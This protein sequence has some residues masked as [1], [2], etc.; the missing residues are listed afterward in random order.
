[1]PS[2]TAPPRPALSMLLAAVTAAVACTGD[3][4]GPEDPVPTPGGRHA[5]S[6]ISVRAPVGSEV[7]VGLAVTDEAGVPLAG[8]EV[9][10]SVTDGG[11]SLST[12]T[13]VM[14]GPTGNAAATW[15]L[16]TH[17]GIN[18]L[19]AKPAGLTPLVFSASAE[20]GP[21]AVIEVAAGNNQEGAV[22][23]PLVLPLRVRLRDEYG[24]EVPNTV[25]QF[26]ATL[27]GGHFAVDT[28]RTNGSGV[29]TST[30]WILGP[31]DVQIA[32]ARR[33]ALSVDMTATLVACPT[34]AIATG[35]AIAGVLA[36][37]DCLING[38]RAD[39]YEHATTTEDAV[40]VTLTSD[41]FEPRLT[42]AGEDGVPRADGTRTY[43]G[44]PVV[45]LTAPG[46]RVFTVRSANTGGTGDYTLT[47]ADA[48][49]ATDGCV[50]VYVERGVSTSQQIDTS[51]C[52][53]E[54]YDPIYYD[55]LYI[56]LEAGET[57]TA[58]MTA[59]EFTPHATLYRPDGLVQGCEGDL[60]TGCEFIAMSAGYFALRVGP[61][62]AFVVGDYALSIE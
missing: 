44:G 27:G 48:S 38:A 59:A 9:S 51:D 33:G 11:G 43:P 35:D 22:A 15:V 6:A 50:L 19:S 58:I 13:V 57:F 26:T 14:T 52:A 23:E 10:F 18:R 31:A 53:A 54:F 34:S 29:A 40:A 49:G 39:R 32:T 42:I 36:N 3:T 41:V 45:V 37:G 30:P 28:A 12:E 8:I 61:N 17:T 2:H 16:G 60:A 55:L 1:M 62:Q 47:I 20:A 21:P 56:Y 4:S 7:D 25:V 46:F 24:N 5:T